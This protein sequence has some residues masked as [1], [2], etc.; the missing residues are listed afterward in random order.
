[1]TDLNLLDTHGPAAPRLRP[2]VLARARRDLV[3]AATPR[4]P[5]RRARRRLALTGAA[6]ALATAM[7]VVPSA[8]R[9]T[10]STAIALVPMDPLTFPLTPGSVPADLTGV[11]F[12]FDSGFRS[13]RYRGTG[14]DRLSVTTGVAGKDHWSIPEDHRDVQISGNNAVLYESTAYHGT[15][16]KIPST[17]VVWKNE[18]GDW[19]RVSGDGRYADDEAV[20]SFATSLRNEPQEVRTGVGLEVAPRGWVLAAYKEGRILTMTPR[21]HGPDSADALT[22][23]LTGHDSLSDYGA[24]DTSTETVDGREV[25]VGKA[26]EGWAALGATPDGQGYSVIAPASFTRTQV[27]EVAAG[28]TYT[29]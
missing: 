13:V 2:E 16:T 9:S 26:G 17:S 29:P 1:M 22:V 5:R 28:V 18:D 15:S 12:E 4:S 14:D 3:A 7:I 19:T 21:G 27:A 10:G 6:L 24:G 25:E 8:L 11:V 20:M 23:S